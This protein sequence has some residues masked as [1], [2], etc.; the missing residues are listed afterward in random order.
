MINLSNCL[1]MSD[2][3]LSL[4]HAFS[5]TLDSTLISNR[6]KKKGSRVQAIVFRW[7]VGPQGSTIEF[8]MG[9]FVDRSGKEQY[10]KRNL[11]NTAIQRFDKNPLT[12]DVLGEVNLHRVKQEIRH[13]I[14][15]LRK[16][17]L[18]STVP[19]NWCHEYV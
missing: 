16:N 15:R 11:R 5:R 19:E 10:C 8:Q 9:S 13:E 7:I 4:K 12:V 18:L 3:A 14:Q 17:A 2:N 1:R 6:Q